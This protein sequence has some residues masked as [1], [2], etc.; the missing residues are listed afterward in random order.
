MVMTDSPRLKQVEVVDW[1][2]VD[3][4]NLRGAFS[5]HALKALGKQ[6]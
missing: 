1:A 2:I 6:Q 3:E 5:V 4:G